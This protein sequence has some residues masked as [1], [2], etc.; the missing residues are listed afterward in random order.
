MIF[1][2]TYQAQFFFFVKKSLLK[3]MA[4]SDMHD[5]PVSV[6]TITPW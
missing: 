3:V 5:R 6:M 2:Q 4:L 1:A